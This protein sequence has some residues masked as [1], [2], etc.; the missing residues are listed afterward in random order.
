[1]KR[2]ATLPNCDR[3]GKFMRCDPGASW[4]MRFSGV[5]PPTPDHEVFRCMRCTAV[6]G[7]IPPSHG[8]KPEM[9]SGVFE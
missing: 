6:H 1:M 2:Y 8:V 9:T 7:S 4:A 3:C 5:P